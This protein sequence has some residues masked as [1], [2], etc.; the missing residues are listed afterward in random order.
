MGSEQEHAAPHRVIWAQNRSVQLHNFFKAIR[1][2]RGNRY[3]DHVVGK[4]DQTNEDIKRPNAKTGL[5]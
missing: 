3:P 4:P 5:Q 2:S 1:G